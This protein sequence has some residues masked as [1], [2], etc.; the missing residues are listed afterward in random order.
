MTKKKALAKQ[1]FGLDGLVIFDV[2]EI[3]PGENLLGCDLVPLANSGDGWVSI[4]NRSDASIF[5]HITKDSIL[6]SLKDLSG[7]PSSGGKTPD[8]SLV[9]H[10]PLFD[11]EEISARSVL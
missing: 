6:L 10:P 1:D 5:L 4:A 3:K 11:S 2:I 8:E 9:I 7:Q